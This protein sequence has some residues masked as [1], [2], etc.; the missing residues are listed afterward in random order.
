MVTGRVQLAND[1]VYACLRYGQV[2]AAEHDAGGTIDF[3]IWEMA[4]QKPDETLVGLYPA[5][6][7]RR[8]ISEIVRGKIDHDDV[9]RPLGKIPGTARLGRD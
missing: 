2:I 8:A 7:I 6:L 1:L 9:G 3:R 4:A 5:D